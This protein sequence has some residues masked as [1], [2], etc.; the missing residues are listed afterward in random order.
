MED[1]GNRVNLLLCIYGGVIDDSASYSGFKFHL[2]I[3]IAAHLEL[4]IRTRSIVLAPRARYW[5]SLTSRHFE[6]FV[7]QEGLRRKRCQ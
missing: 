5:E 4:G 2:P 1:T 3:G 6:F 7:S